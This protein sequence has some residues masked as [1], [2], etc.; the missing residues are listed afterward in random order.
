MRDTAQT[1]LALITKLSSL[2][3]DKPMETINFI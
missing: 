3:W 2:A 1:A